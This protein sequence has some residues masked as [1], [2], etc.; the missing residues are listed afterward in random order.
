MATKNGDS[1]A[2][3][4]FGSVMAIL[5]V[6]AALVAT[7]RPMQQRIDCNQVTIAEL[8]K[9]TAELRVLLVT[10]LTDLRVE[11]ATMQVRLEEMER[12]VAEVEGNT[13][14]PLYLDPST[15]GG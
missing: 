2:A 10:E 8:V 3:K 14:T 15:G 11:Q 9:Q 5:A 13:L 6:V 7:T 12:R 1:G 4:A